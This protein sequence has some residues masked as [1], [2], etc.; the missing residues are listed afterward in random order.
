MNLSD[1]ITVSG[2]TGLFKIISQTKNGMI[3]ESLIDQK[4]FPTYITDRVNKLDDIFVYTVSSEII[5]KDLFLKIYEKEN[6][7]QALDPKSDDKK[8]KTYFEEVLPDYN[9]EKVY[10]SDMKKII[11]WYN[12][13]NKQGLITPDEKPEEKPAEENSD[14][15]P[16][17]SDPE[18]TQPEDKKE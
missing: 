13:L 6:G 2:K 18:T 14:N 10:V 9:K 3:I 17:K 1:I 7:A 8:L 4:R 5:L 15:N 12:I 11:S 16:V